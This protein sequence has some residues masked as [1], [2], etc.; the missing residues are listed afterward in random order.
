MEDMRSRPLV[1]LSCPCSNPKSV[2]FLLCP[3]DLAVAGCMTQ[4]VKA[5][6]VTHEAMPAV[7]S[8]KNDIGARTSKHCA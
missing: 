3:F 6:K 7:P 1:L 2:L 4:V 5:C 8:R